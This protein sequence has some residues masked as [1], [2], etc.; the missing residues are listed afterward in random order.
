MTPLT[1]YLANLSA[2]RTLAEQPRLDHTRL[3]Q[4]QLDLYEG[5]ADERL[6]R[7]GY[8]SALCCQPELRKH[9]EPL[10]IAPESL[11]TPQGLGA[12]QIPE[13]LVDSVVEGDR[14]SVV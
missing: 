8:D 10:G 13:A 6:R 2:L 11:V 4:S 5:W 1:R 3:W 7:M 12:L 9:L 14:K